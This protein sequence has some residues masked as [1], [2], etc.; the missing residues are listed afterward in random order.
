MTDLAI[1]TTCLV[2]SLLLIQTGMHIGI[3][4]MLLSFLG[5]WAIRGVE[6]AGRLLGNSVTSSIADDAYAV[7]PLFVLMGLFVSATNMGR[8]TFDV[9]ARALRKIRGGLGMATVAANAIFAACT[10]T[11]IASASV[12]TKVAVPEMV[13]HG[14]TKRFSVGVVAGSSVLGML[15]PPSIL[16]IIYGVIAN[17]SIGDMFKAGILPGILLSLLFCLTI[18]ALARFRPSMVAAD[19]R[20]LSGGYQ[21]ALDDAGSLAILMK[22]LPIIV[23]VVVV[24]GGIYGGYFTPTEAGG[25][26]ALAAFLIALTRRELTPKVFW[27]VALET[28]RVT[29]AICF[30]LM[31]AALYAQ[32]LTMSGLPYTVGQWLQ[33]S[34]LPF[35]AILIGYLVVLVV[36]GFFLDSVSIMLIVLPFVIPVFN[37]LG[38]DLIWLGLISII[39]IEVGLLTPPLGIAVFVV[40]AN[41]EDQ[42]ISVWDIFMGTLPM[43]MAMLSVLFLC[44]LVPWLALAPTGSAWTW[45]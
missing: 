8:D 38:V 34:Q 45:W 33:S 5:V 9:A 1:G 37:G 28:G 4:L 16:M 18:A 12:F 24:L 22:C 43:V 7:I 32:M 30:L 14:F 21:S 2:A 20:A 23:L 42:T 41:L 35:L 11:S 26:G 44:I 36:L 3:A 6:V 17:V 39:A 31:A 19:P 13:R 29:A 10:G 25:V 40:K 27:A 15:I